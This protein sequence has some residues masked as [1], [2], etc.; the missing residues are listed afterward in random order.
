MED[1]KC[2]LNQPALQAE[3]PKF[4]ILDDGGNLANRVAVTRP[5]ELKLTNSKH[6]QNEKKNDEEEDEDYN[7]ADNELIEVISFRKQACGGNDNDSNLADS[8]TPFSFRIQPTSNFIPVAPNKKTAFSRMNNN[9]NNTLRVEDSDDGDSNVYDSFFSG[10]MHDSQYSEPAEHFRLMKK[11]S[12]F[13]QKNNVK[14]KSEGAQSPEKEVNFNLSG[15]LFAPTFSKTK[16]EVSKNDKKGEGSSEKLNLEPPGLPSKHS[17]DETL[18]ENQKFAGGFKDKKLSLKQLE[19]SEVVVSPEEDGEAK[20]DFKIA[21]PAIEIEVPCN[22]ERK[23]SANN[24]AESIKSAVP[25]IDKGSVSS[26]TKKTQKTTPKIEQL[27]ENEDKSRRRSLTSS[28]NSLQSSGKISLMEFDC[29]EI[30]MTPSKFFQNAKVV[31]TGKKEPQAENSEVKETSIRQADSPTKRDP[32][33]SE[34]GNLRPK[35]APK[36]KARTGQDLGGDSE[37]QNNLFAQ[38]KQNPLKSNSNTFN[39]V[40]SSKLDDEGLDNDKS[41]SSMR[42][43]SPMESIKNR[44]RNTSFTVKISNFG[45]GSPISEKT[46]EPKFKS[47]SEKRIA[48]AELLDPGNIEEE[49]LDSEQG[50]PVKKGLLTFGRRSSKHLSTLSS[51]SDVT[52]KLEACERLE[53]VEKILESF[54]IK[55]EPKKSSLSQLSQLSEDTEVDPVYYPNA[56]NVG[57][58]IKMMDRSNPLLKPKHGK[59]TFFRNYK[60][61]QVDKS[62]S[63]SEDNEPESGS[64]GQKGSFGE[65]NQIEDRT[66]SHENGG[67]KRMRLKSK[68]QNLDF[69]EEV[70]DNKSV[71]D[72]NVEMKFSE[73]EGSPNLV[74]MRRRSEYNPPSG[75]RISNQSLPMINKYIAKKNQVA[76]IEAKSQSEMPG[77]MVR[78]A[79]ENENEQQLSSSCSSAEEVENKVS[80]RNVKIEAKMKSESDRSEFVSRE[81]RAEDN[82]D[83]GSVS[84]DS[85]SASSSSIDEVQVFKLVRVPAIKGKRRPPQYCYLGADE[86]SKMKDEKRDSKEKWV[87]LARPVIQLTTPSDREIAIF[88]GK[89]S[90]VEGGE[91]K[92]GDTGIDELKEPKKVMVVVKSKVNI[93]NNKVMENGLKLDGRSIGEDQGPESSQKSASKRIQRMLETLK[94]SKGN[95][96]K[97]EKNIK[98]QLIGTLNDIAD[99]GSVRDSSD[100]L[101]STLDSRQ[102]NTQILKFVKENL[103]EISDKLVNQLQSQQELG[104]KDLIESSKILKQPDLAKI[105]IQPAKKNR[106]ENQ[107]R[108]LIVGAK[109]LNKTPISGSKKSLLKVSGDFQA[110]NQPDEKNPILVVVEEEFNKNIHKSL[111]Q[112]EEDFT[113]K[114]LKEMKEVQK[115]AIDSVL[116]KI[117]KNSFKEYQNTLK[118]ADEATDKTMN[119]IIQKE[120][121]TSNLWSPEIGPLFHQ[122]IEK[123]SIYEEASTRFIDS[124]LP[125]LIKCS[126][127]RLQIM[128][129][130]SAISRPSFDTCSSPLIECRSFK[131]PVNYSPGE[132]SIPEKKRIIIPKNMPNLHLNLDNRT[133]LSSLLDHKINKTREKMKIRDSCDNMIEEALD[134][135]EDLYS[136]KLKKEVLEPVAEEFVT[137]ILG[138]Y[139]EEMKREVLEEVAEDFV[140]DLIEKFVENSRKLEIFVSP[141]ESRRISLEQRNP[142]NDSPDSIFDKG[143]QFLRAK[144]TLKIQKSLKNIETRS[145][146]AGELN[147]DKNTSNNV[148]EGLF[149]QIKPRKIQQSAKVVEIPRVKSAHSESFLGQDLHQLTCA[150]L[151]SRYQNNW[152]DSNVFEQVKGIMEELCSSLPASKARGLTEFYRR[153]IDFKFLRS[154]LEENGRDELNA[155]DSIM[156]DLVRKEKKIN[157]K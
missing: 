95:R 75:A 43:P 17:I 96:H 13:K 139:P 41:P 69:V 58:H 21:Q 119:K 56:S 149:V 24:K 154:C 147:T 157:K 49:F 76:I 153:H 47:V 33:L 123:K 29:H 57:I 26:R 64:Q 106:S 7:D 53:G 14:E 103:K 2:W 73:D 102:L 130:D 138:K 136:N 55:D 109:K 140:R 144:R 28:A 34:D 142:F 77:Q 31:Q 52:S 83:D 27:I 156:S 91:M 155:Y 87:L 148:E 80:S 131:P 45:G 143:H 19:N 1:Q 121:L 145:V 46:K 125:D 35:K 79:H 92:G 65:Q 132:I 9:K 128:G 84:D 38:K 97:F 62:E 74:R 150:E 85:S 81:A 40:D 114:E 151:E 99:N 60:K 54:D 133:S 112:Y 124:M 59:S 82:D 108:E 122:K 116:Q 105:E 39:S 50:S 16:D 61:Q 71:S 68:S 126:V 20:R 146:Q 141:L 110:T 4:T 70:S 63:P 6:S 51:K 94:P 44:R 30:K 152:F 127:R 113:T 135:Y 8:P 78:E 42:N 89:E 88:K 134:E 5:P 100:K 101:K 12:K 104:S 23:T 90:Q 18:Q 118:L 98:K 11:A 15:G 72:I 115:L 86:I 93:V 66:N 120:L 22:L 32:N 129:R 137:T 107:C 111:D 25:S 67:H 48:E 37:T 36:K 3:S 10:G 117:L